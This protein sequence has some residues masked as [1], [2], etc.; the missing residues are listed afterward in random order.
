MEGVPINLIFLVVWMFVC[1]INLKERDA[2]LSRL[3]RN[4]SVAGAQL[5]SA[6]CISP[7]SKPNGDQIIF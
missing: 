5:P 7:A 1:R 4:E 2:R 3:G 6:D